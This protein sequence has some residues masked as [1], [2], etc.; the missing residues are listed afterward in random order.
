MNIPTATPPPKKR[1]FF[2]KPP[3]RPSGEFLEKMTMDY[4]A[5]PAKVQAA[6]VAAT[7]IKVRNDLFN[8]A[9]G[10]D[11]GRSRRHEAVWYL[12]KCAFFLTPLPFPSSIKVR[13]LRWFGASIGRGVVIKPRVNIHFPWK[14]SVGNHSWIGEEV[15]ILNFEPVTI[16]SHCCISQRAF[17]CTGNH[18][19][20]QPDMC[21]RNRPIKI[22]DGA[23]VGAQVFVSPE[24]TIG[25]EAVITAGSVVTKSQPAKMVCSG[26]PCLAHKQRWPEDYSNALRFHEFQEVSA[27]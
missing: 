21:Y 3:S 22:E 24:V 4:P 19:F 18:D 14:L 7:A 23:W 17:L 2:K 15:S 5:L 26:N 9:K 6:P 10:L 12:V 27:G 1:Q 16:G 20:R 25:S 8:P 13:V 11:R